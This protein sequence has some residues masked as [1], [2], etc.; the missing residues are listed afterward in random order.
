MV[1]CK[2]LIFSNIYFILSTLPYNHHTN[3]VLSLNIHMAHRGFSVIG[4]KQYGDFRL[5][6][7]VK[8]LR[9]YL[10]A[11]SVEIP[12]PSGE[13]GDTDNTSVYY[14]S[15]CMH[16]CLSVFVRI[17]IHQYTNALPSL[18]VQSPLSCR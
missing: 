4:D 16:V 1:H 13:V 11:E 12:M 7:L 15:V 6:K 2:T 3:N 5:S 9:M 14:V 18:G 17:L 10:H 8:P